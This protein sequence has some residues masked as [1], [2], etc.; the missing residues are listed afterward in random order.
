MLAAGALL[1]LARRPGHRGP[2]ARRRPRGSDR[3]EAALLPE[4]CH[5]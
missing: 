2:E 1:A 5:D 4:A 3:P